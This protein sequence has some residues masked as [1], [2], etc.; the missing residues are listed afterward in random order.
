MK[1]L[2]YLALALAGVIFA[3]CMGS[4]YADP[5]LDESPYG[6]NSI[7]TTNLVTIA[8][9]KAKYKNKITGNSYTT[10]SED[11]QIK[12]IVTGNDRGGNIYQEISIQDETGALLVCV[13][14]SGLYGYLPEGQEVI[15]DLKDLIIGGYGGQAEVGGIYTNTNTGA[16]GVGRMDRYTWEKHY[17][18][19]GEPDTTKLNSLK[20]DF[21]VSKLSDASYIFD[22]AGKLMTIKGVT[23]KDANGKNVYAPNDGSVSLTSNCA[24]RAFTGYNSSNLCLRTST[25]ADFANDIIKSGTCDV[26]GIF[27]IYNS[28]W[29]ILARDLNDIK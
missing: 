5:T 27:T 4:S 14:A 13:S 16:K 7:E 21:D 3:S 26:T 23:F 10:I 9:L 12:G 8:Q 25:Y 6:D 29:Q 15:I 17:K 20:E 19:V 22:N 11:M 2:K 1:K 28:T 18:L 24:N